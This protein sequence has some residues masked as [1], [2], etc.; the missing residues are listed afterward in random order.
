MEISPL[1]KKIL[2]DFQLPEDNFLASILQIELPNQ[3]EL[4]NFD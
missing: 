4:I 1:E 2:A 3:E